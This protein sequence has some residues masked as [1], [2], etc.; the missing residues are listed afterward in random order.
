MR[1]TAIHTV[2]Y[3]SGAA[4]FIVSAAFVAQRIQRAI[5]KKAVKIIAAMQRVTRKIFAFAVAKK[6]V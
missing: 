4:V 3:L 6:P 5:T 2:F 1:Q